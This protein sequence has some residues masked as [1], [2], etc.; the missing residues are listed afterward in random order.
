LADI[1]ELQA[2]K[3]VTVIERLRDAGRMPLGIMSYNM[4]KDRVDL[5]LFFNVDPTEANAILEK[6]GLEANFAR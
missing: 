2:I 5:H 3:L 4:D 6:F 1:G